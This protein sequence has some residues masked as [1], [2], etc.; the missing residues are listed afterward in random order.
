MIERSWSPQSVRNLESVRACIAEDSPA[1]AALT[2]QRILTAVERLRESPDSDRTVPEFQSHNPRDG[3][4]GSCRVVYRL[5][6]AK[7]E[8]VT[9]FR[10]S[11]TFPASLQQFRLTSVAAR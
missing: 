2:V 9:V 5:T 4:V 3:M 11:L 7:V 6:S 10:G 1:C 8:I